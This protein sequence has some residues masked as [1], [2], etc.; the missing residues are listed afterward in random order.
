MFY[1]DSFILAIVAI[2]YLLSCDQLFCDNMG[3]SSP[4][5]SVHGIFQERILEEIAISFSRRS[6]QTRDRTHI[7]CISRQ[8]LYTQPPGKLPYL[9]IVSMY[10]IAITFFHSYTDNMQRDGKS[11]EAICNNLALRQDYLIIPLIESGVQGEQ[12]IYE[13]CILQHEP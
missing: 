5:S 11:K 10:F 2:I 6:S 9:A 12:R 8:I 4:G 3:C 13:P 7:S 1:Q